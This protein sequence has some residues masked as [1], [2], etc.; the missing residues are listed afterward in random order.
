MSRVRY[1]DFKRKRSGLPKDVAAL[2]EKLEAERTVLQLVNL[3]PTDSREV[4]VQ[5]GAFGEHQF[6]Q[7]KYQARTD[8]QVEDKI[9]EV[10]DK[11]FHVQLSPGTQITLEIGTKRFVSNP[12]YDFPW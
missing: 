11:C 8:G 1:F 5:A 4:I 10:N 7:V 9:A 2:V 6:T 12:T 3:S